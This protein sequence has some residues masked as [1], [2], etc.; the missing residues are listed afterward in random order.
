MRC[1][2]LS[3]PFSSGFGAGSHQPKGADRDKAD[4]QARVE[5]DH[6]ICALEQSMDLAL[7]S[8]KSRWANV[9]LGTP[10]LIL[11][12]PASYANHALMAIPSTAPYASSRLSASVGCAW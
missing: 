10:T 8:R 9:H 12:Q 2:H 4:A 3:S 6:S 7:C 1:V 11:A 5:E